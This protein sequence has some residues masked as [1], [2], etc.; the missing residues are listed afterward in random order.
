M[1]RVEVSGPSGSLVVV[2]DFVGAPAVAVREC[3]RLFAVAW[4]DAFGVRGSTYT[5]RIVE[6]TAAV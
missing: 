3:E 6:K 4:Y 5:G 1:K 2:I